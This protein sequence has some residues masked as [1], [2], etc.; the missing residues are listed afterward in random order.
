V[1]LAA[2]PAKGWP[3]SR[4]T[5]QW[6]TKLDSGAQQH[7]IQPPHRMLRATC[8]GQRA[9]P[10]PKLDHRPARKVE[11]QARAQASARGLWRFSKS[12]ILHRFPNFYTLRVKTFQIFL[13]VNVY[14]WPP[15]NREKF[16]GNRF[17][18]FSKIRKTDTQ[19]DVA[20]LYI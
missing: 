9:W 5:G 12:V 6:T 20:T 16:H 19:T 17:A 8:A 11:P 3:G 1:S 4:T 7:L 13:S 2:Y 10:M 15:L 14:I 18:H